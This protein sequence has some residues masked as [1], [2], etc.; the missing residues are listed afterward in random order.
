MNHNE[1]KHYDQKNELKDQLF[2]D[3]QTFWQG[4]CTII[5]EALIR[6]KNFAL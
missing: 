4:I 3:S 5:V 1:L 6:Q 2:Y